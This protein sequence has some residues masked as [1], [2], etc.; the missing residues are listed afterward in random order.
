MKQKYKSDFLRKINLKGTFRF[1]A[2]VMS[3]VSVML[4]LPFSPIFAKGSDSYIW[5]FKAGEKGNQPLLIDGNSIV[6]HP[7]LLSMGNP[8]E[9]VIYLTFDAGYST[10]N[11]EKILDV[12]KEEQV[13]AAF[14]ILPAIY[15]YT[16]QVAARMADE[17]HLVCNHTLTHANVAKLSAEETEREL[18]SLEAEYE[19]YTGNKM[20]KYFRPPEGI[21]SETTLSVCEKLGYKCVFWSF[22][23]ADWD[24]NAQKDVQWAKEKILS[25]AHNGEVML[26][27][28]NSKTNA[29]I[30]K[31]V[32]RQL[33]SEGYTFETLDR[34][35]K[36][37]EQR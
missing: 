17:G 24:N 20:A 6:E 27:H 23:Y 12:L 21:F 22:A 32:I 4:T 26:L 5:H 10:E 29:T 19:N 7:A 33:K 30:L 13:S 1:V 11:V 8:D 14:F 25:T 3:A 35:S 15:K 31:D 36:E 34:L 9:K 28:P 16:P 2:F 18:L 37:K